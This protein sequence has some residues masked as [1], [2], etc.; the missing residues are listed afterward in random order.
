M[1]STILERSVRPDQGGDQETDR[2]AFSRLVYGSAVLLHAPLS[3]RALA[4]VLG[5]SFF[6]VE[7]KLSNLE[8]IFDIEYGLHG[9]VQ[10]SHPSFRDF[11]IDDQ[12]CTNANF[13]IDEKETHKVLRAG[14]ISLMSRQLKK[15]ICQLDYS[16]TLS[17]DIDA[18]EVGRCIDPEL[19]YACRY[20]ASHFLQSHFEPRDQ[21]EVHQFLEKHILNWIE[22]MGLIGSG[23]QVDHLLR[24]YQDCVSVP[25]PQ[26]YPALFISFW[27]RIP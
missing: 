14:C 21:D 23:R 1:Y 12:R 8:C 25:I 11:I 9:F 26:K 18:E 7:D 17:G 16:A 10:L 22:V 2:Y 13:W 3:M 5:I 20:W 6:G 19:Q 15:N 27:L 4:A 24:Q